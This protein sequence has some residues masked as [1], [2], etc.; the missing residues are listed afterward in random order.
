MTFKEFSTLYLMKDGQECSATSDLQ[1]PALKDWDHRLPK[2][3]DWREKGVVSP[4]KDQ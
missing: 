3:F 4:I 1:H 2:S